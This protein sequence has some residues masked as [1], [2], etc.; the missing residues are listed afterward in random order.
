M[1]VQSGDFYIGWIQPAGGQYYNGRD[2]DGS[3][4]GRS[5][6]LSSDGNWQNVSEVGQEHD[7]MLRQGCRDEQT[8]ESTTAAACGLGFELG[9]ILPLLFWLRHRRRFRTA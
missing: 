6:L 4:T 7:L 3:Y 9:A 8:P 2:D 5:Y 1:T